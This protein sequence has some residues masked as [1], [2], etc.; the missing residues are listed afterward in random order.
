MR[1]IRNPVYGYAVTWV[2]IPPSP[3]WTCLIRDRDSIDDVNRAEQARFCVLGSELVRRHEPTFA[4]FR[5]EVS[6]PKL[7]KFG[8]HNLRFSTLR[9]LA[10]VSAPAIEIRSAF[11]RTASRCRAGSSA[12]RTL[13]SPPEPAFRIRSHRACSSLRLLPSSCAVVR[14]TCGL[15]I[16]SPIGA[17]PLRDPTC[18]RSLRPRSLGRIDRG[19]WSITLWSCAP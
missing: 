13:R 19:P 16:V 14:R 8:A 12:D 4:R 10:R 17:F 6:G 3:P 1:R 18:A 7:S 11:P 5:A 15:I 2:R 9:R